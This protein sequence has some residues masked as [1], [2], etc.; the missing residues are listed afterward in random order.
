VLLYGGSFLRIQYEPRAST[1][2]SD[3]SPSLDFV[4]TTLV[5]A[6]LTSRGLKFWSCS[7]TRSFG[8][9]FPLPFSL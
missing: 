5:S 8:S 4:P 3:T 6:I 7:E 2:G 9:C 1:T